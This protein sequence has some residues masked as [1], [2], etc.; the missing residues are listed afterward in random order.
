MIA[1]KIAIRIIQ[2]TTCATARK[3]ESQT[4]N[5]VSISFMHAFGSLHPT[6]K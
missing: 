6:A 4:Q 2:P 1:T 5:S 3:N